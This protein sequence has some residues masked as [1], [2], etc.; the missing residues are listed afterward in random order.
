MLGQRWGR[1]GPGTMQNGTEVGQSGT[2][3][4]QSKTGMRQSGIGTGM[5]QN[6]TGKFKVGEGHCRAGQR[7]RA[8][9][10]VGMDHRGAG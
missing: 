1:V 5:R 7:G 4:R 3:T 6:Q 8:R 10:G 2:G 9:S